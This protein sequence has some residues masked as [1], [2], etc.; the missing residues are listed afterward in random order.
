[1]AS[2]FQIRVLTVA[3]VLPSAA[4]VIPAEA[5]IQDSWARHLD[6][7]P[8]ARQIGFVFSNRLS[9]IRITQ[10]SI[11]NRLALFF[12]IVLATEET[13][14]TEKVNSAD[15]PH[16]IALGTSLSSQLVGQMSDDRR[17]TRYEFGF[18]WLCFLALGTGLYSIILSC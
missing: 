13:E 8:K 15:W 14:V 18:D 16:S 11:R 7:P 4:P 6:L 1:M 2:F 5:G 9:A 10:Y 3:V 17:V 12:Q